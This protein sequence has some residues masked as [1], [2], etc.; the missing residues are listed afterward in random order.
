MTKVK[1]AFHLHAKAL[2]NRFL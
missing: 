2:K 1:D